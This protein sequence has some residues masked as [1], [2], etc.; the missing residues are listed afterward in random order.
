MANTQTTLST[1][2]AGR[3]GGEHT[4]L[5][6][7]VR[8]FRKETTAIIGL[9]I[10]IIFVA[11]A[12]L[13]GLL[14]PYPPLEQHISDSLH[15][16]S[17]D[18]LFGADKLG[19]DVFSRILYGAR[20]SLFTGLSVVLIA[21]SVGT[22][23]GTVAGYI[24]GWWDEAIMRITDI[25]FAFPSLILAMAIAGAL[26]PSLQNALIAVAVVSWPVYARLVRGQVLVLRDQ[27]FVQAAR[28]IGVGDAGILLR[29]ILPNTLSPLLVQASFDMGGTILAVSG[30]SF[31]GFG[32]QPPTPE[33]GVMISEGRNYITAQWWLTLF[34]AISMLLVVTG[35]NLVG[36]G[37]RDIL[38]PR[39]NK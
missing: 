28:A 1:P 32:A 8:R 9:V 16:P 3:A 11:L 24:G 12:A 13:A 23:I 31:I 21:A 5:R 6:M 22:L 35:F 36:D 34:P 2:A 29:H 25:F 33:W 15:A 20:I 4:P 18:H 19:R 10:I 7:F 17:L 39:L 30:L 27:E 14:S 37:L 38:D 26:G